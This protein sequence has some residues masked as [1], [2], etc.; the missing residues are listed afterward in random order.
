MQTYLPETLGHEVSARSTTAAA[1][2]CE[3]A[4]SLVVAEE[5]SAIAVL[6]LASRVGGADAALFV[7]VVPG[8]KE[9]LWFRSLAALDHRWGASVLRRL[10]EGP[11][12]WLAHAAR[13]SEPLLVRES[14][15]THADGTAAAAASAATSGDSSIRAAWL[16]P[17][18]SPQ[19]SDALGLLI[20]ASTDEARLDVTRAVLPVY[21][22]LALALAEWFQRRGREELVQRAHL[23]DRDLELLRHE[24]MGHGSKRIAAALQAEPKTI[25]CRF[26][27]LNVR[28]GVANRRDAVRLCQ[29]YGLL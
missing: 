24:Q 20:L 9:Q 4:D 23:T 25:D 28:L 13:S 29:R 16:V 27:R 5:A 26:H 2:L 22:A 18:P 1:E 19:S 10:H 11:C 3:L 6:E 12:N 21:R 17:A 15:D 7:W 8:H 14:A